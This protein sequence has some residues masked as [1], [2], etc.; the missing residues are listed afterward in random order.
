MEFL[1]GWTSA[2]PIESVTRSEMNSALFPDADDVLRRAA[3]VRTKHRRACAGCG[4]VESEKRGE[5]CA[6][7]AGC[8]RRAKGSR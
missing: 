7:L 3:Q 5:W 8:G 6:D 4:S 1:G 2:A